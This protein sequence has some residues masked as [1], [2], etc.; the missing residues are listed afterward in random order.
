MRRMIGKE[1]EA[2]KEEKGREGER[3]RDGFVG[4]A[5]NKSGNECVAET[6]KCHKMM[7]MMMM[8]WCW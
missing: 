4:A 3:E 2:R 8:R 1:G 5:C 6:S 7:M